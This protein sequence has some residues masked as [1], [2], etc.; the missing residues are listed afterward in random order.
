MV[1]AHSDTNIKFWSVLTQFGFR[2]KSS[3]IINMIIGY[4]LNY[5]KKVPFELMIIFKQN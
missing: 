3:D 2:L 4:S 5:D 1:E